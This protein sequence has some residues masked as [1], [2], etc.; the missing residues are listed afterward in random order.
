MNFNISPIERLILESLSR[1]PKEL[2][3][4]MH[5]TK[6]DKNVIINILQSLLVKNLLTVDSNRYQ[7]NSNLNQALIQQ[8]KNEQNTL[9][10]IGQVVKTTIKHSLNYKDNSFKYKKVYMNNDEEKI[11]K[12]MLIQLE[13]FIEGL[14][15]K[16]GKTFEQKVIF[17]GSNSYENITTDMLNSY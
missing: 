4:L 6:M 11:F 5:D 14:D 3:E 16:K 9:I 2:F 1:S 13:T 17:W 8:I 15:K 12:A 10:E 7:I